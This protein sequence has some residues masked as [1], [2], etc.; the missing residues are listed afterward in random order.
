MT[1]MTDPTRPPDGQAS[2]PVAVMDS[3]P[4][5]KNPERHVDRREDFGDRLSYGISG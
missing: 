1:M 4:E 3:P 2:A 5:Q